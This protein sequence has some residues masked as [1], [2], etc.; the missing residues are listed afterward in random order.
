MASPNPTYDNSGPELSYYTYEGTIAHCQL[1]N[2]KFE[3]RNRKRHERTAIHTAQL[4]AY[5]LPLP[6]EE[7][8]PN[9][10]VNQKASPM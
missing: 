10:E 9:S 5:G 6:D 1:C 3:K 7:D 8:D 4:R 2:S